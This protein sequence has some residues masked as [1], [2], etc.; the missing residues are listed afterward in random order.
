MKVSTRTWKGIASEIQVIEAER[1]W[2]YMVVIMPLMVY[3]VIFGIIVVVMSM[4]GKMKNPI[5]DLFV[6]IIGIVIIVVAIQ[7]RFHLF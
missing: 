1:K 6:A 5:V 3:C 4:L 7:A 2:K